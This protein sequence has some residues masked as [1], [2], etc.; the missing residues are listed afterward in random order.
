MSFLVLQDQQLWG[1]ERREGEGGKEGEGE[2]EGGEEV[3]GEEEGGEEVEG[4]EKGKEEGSDRGNGGEESVDSK[5]RKLFVYI[6]TLLR[7]IL[8]SCY[9]TTGNM[10]S[11]KVLLR[12]HR[13][14]GTG[15]YTC[16]CTCKVGVTSYIV[17]PDK[18]SRECL[19]RHNHIYLPKVHQTNCGFVVLELRVHLPHHHHKHLQPTQAIK[20][21]QATTTKKQSF[22]ERAHIFIHYYTTGYVQFTCTCTYRGATGFKTI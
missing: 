5:P 12:V 18:P 17:G 11:A 15:V 6:Y 20:Q 1:G 2:E 21:D 3:G 13:V 9:R 22:Q 7:P 4:E 19:V 14:G 8:Y 10:S 16:T